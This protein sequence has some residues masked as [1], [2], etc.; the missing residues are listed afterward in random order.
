[1]AEY[2]GKLLAIVGANAGQQVDLAGASE[3]Y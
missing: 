2:G 3:S 1:M